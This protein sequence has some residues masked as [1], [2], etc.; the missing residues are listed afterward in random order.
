[1]QRSMNLLDLVWEKARSIPGMDPGLF[2][3]DEEGRMIRKT[4]FNNESSIYG[5]CYYHLQPV[6]EGGNDDVWNIKPLNYVNK[7]LTMAVSF[8]GLNEEVI[9]WD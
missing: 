4:D 9:L 3:T 8:N 5:W 7:L 1:M 6:W 2:R